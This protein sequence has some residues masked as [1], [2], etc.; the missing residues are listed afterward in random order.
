MTLLFAADRFVVTFH[1][2]NQQKHG[3]ILYEPKS[4][5]LFEIIINDLVSSF[6]F[7]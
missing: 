7:T 5:F 1:S 2:F 3:N 6:R 4:F